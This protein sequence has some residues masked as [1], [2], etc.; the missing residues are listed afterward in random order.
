M[1]RWQ[2]NALA[3]LHARLLAK[4]VQ[5]FSHPTIRSCGPGVTGASRPTLNQHLGPEE[6]NNAPHALIRILT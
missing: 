3:R 6:D 4:Y 2:S 1:H 5:L